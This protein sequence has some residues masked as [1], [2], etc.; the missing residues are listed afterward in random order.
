VNLAPA[1][2]GTAAGALVLR[3][4]HQPPPPPWWP[5]AP[6][7]W[8]LAAAVLLALGA[9]AWRAWSR[10]R[11]HRALERLF[12]AGIA[13]AATPAARIAAASTLLRRAA[14]SRD[15]AA[16]AL[17]GDAWLAY[18][19]AGAT[20]PLFAGEDGALL[21]DGGFR[22]DVDAVRADALVAGARRRFLEWMA[23][24]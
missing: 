17:H 20:A 16:G 21:L 2:P 13:A 5:P 15:P 4:I 24:R 18:L 7:W 6:G 23:R 1:D 10:R 22:R 12:D 19:D 9:W 8:L 3:D 14:R 11:R